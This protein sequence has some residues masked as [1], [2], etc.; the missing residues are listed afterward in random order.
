MAWN[1]ATVTKTGLAL[2]EKS[3]L[4]GSIEITSAIAGENTAPAEALKE[5]TDIEQ[6]KHEMEI[7][8]V[9]RAEYG[10]SVDLRLHN[11][12]LM[13]GYR[14]RLIGLFARIKDSGEKSILLAVIQDSEGEEIPAQ[15]DNP[16]YLLEYG[17]VI[18]ISSEANFTA[19]LKPS[20]FAT[21]EDIKN[22]GHASFA[23][24]DEYL[25]GKSG[26]VPAPS[27]GEQEKFLKADGSWQYVSEAHAFAE[28]IRDKSK[29]DYGFKHSGR[30]TLAIETADYTGRSE[31]VLVCRDN[32]L[33]DAENM[34]ENAES[35]RHGDLI[36]EGEQL[37]RTPNTPT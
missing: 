23:G 4:G 26:F 24:A 20:I 8:G 6:P 31:I 10:I 28:R 33:L 27:A 21:K 2:L 19:V 13:S 36:A 1:E 34:T 35:A 25:D 18:P 14:L 37:E 30:L 11:I 15:E 12:G 32:T 22:H 16:E 3:V 29:P 5:M 7:V 9:R 17:F